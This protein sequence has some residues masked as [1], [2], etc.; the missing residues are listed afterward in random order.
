MTLDGIGAIDRIEADR[1][2]GDQRF[3]N[4][5]VRLMTM[6]ERHTA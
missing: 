6:P 2:E 4:I 3:I 5:R 1:E